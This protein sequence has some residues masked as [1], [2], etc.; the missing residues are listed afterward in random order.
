MFAK[1]TSIDKLEERLEFS[2]RCWFYTDDIINALDECLHVALKDRQDEFFLPCKVR[3][4]RPFS[5]TNTSGNF[6]HRSFIISFFLEHFFRS[7]DDE[8]LAL[9]ALFFL[10]RSNGCMKRLH[11]KPLCLQYMDG[12]V[13]AMTRDIFFDVLV[14]SMTYEIFYDSIVIILRQSHANVKGERYGCLLK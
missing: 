2:T 13:H 11:N 9:V 5:D 14:L 4:D 12:C 6:I 1:K 10:Q 3:I 8:F 7:L